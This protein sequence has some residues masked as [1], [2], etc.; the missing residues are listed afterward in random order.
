MRIKLINMTNRD[1]RILIDSEFPLSRSANL[2]WLG[3]SEEGQLMS[4]D[5]EG[6]MRAFT[7]SS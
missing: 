1:Y 2:I 7:F 3:F 5:S 4:F 6:I